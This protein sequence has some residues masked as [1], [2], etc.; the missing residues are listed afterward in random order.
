[1]HAAAPGPAPA[2]T[3][4]TVV[5]VGIGADGW[6]GLSPRARRAVEDADVLRGSARQLALVPDEVGAER[7]PWP[8]PLSD[9]LPDL[10]VRQAGRATVVLA[11]GDP[12][13][14]GIGTTLTRLLGHER[15]RV[16]PAPSAVT[17]ELL[18]MFCA[19]NGATDTPWRTSQR[20]MPAVTTDLP[21]SDVVPATRSA[22]PVPLVLTRDMMPIAVRGAP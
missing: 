2:T 18:L 11:S 19:L 16:L 12:M 6:D 22:P 20:Q 17:I 10:V 15:V 9:A 5:V 13:L 8:S 7:V 21:A 1:M 14:S 4:P 3:G